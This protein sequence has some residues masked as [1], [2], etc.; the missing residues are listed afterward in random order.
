MTVVLWPGSSDDP[1]SSATV[2]SV[3]KQSADLLTVTVHANLSSA[4]VIAVRGE[5]DMYTSPLLQDVLLAQLRPDG[6]P[7]VL[8]LT[9]V[10]FFGAAGLNALITARAA[11]VAVGVRLC[12]VA[13]RRPVLLPLTI[14]GLDREFDIH[15]ALTDALPAPRGGPDG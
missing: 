14:T 12:L 4:V 2:P 13:R 10:D 8:D 5:V 9:D 3:R 7:L 6:P 1:G 11:A 15:P